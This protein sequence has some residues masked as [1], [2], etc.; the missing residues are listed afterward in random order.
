MTPADRPL[1]LRQ[2]SD[3]ADGEIKRLA[4]ALDPVPAG[5]YARESLKNAGIWSRSRT[6]CR[7]TA[8][9][10]PRWPW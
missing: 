5:R 6:A 9:C 4:L 8:T 1:H 10:A 3:L 7:S 2:L